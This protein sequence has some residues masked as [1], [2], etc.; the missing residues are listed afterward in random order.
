MSFIT[1]SQRFS[2]IF[3]T[4]AMCFIIALSSNV[5]AITWDNVAYYKLDETSGTNAVDETGS[6]NLTNYNSVLVNSSG[7]IGTSYNWS[8]AT[9]KY[10]QTTSDLIS[11]NLSFNT[12]VYV[13]SI[14]NADTILSIYDSSPDTS[15]TIQLINTTHIRT[16]CG[17]ATCSGFDITYPIAGYLNKWTMVSITVDDDSDNITLYLDGSLVN[18]DVGVFAGFTNVDEFDIGNGDNR[19]RT[20]A[21]NGRQDEISVWDR[22]LVSDDITDLYNGGAGLAYNNQPNVI[23]ITLDSPSNATTI[24][25]IGANFTTSS[26]NLSSISG[27]WDNI[28]YY[29][30][31]DN[32]TL[33]NQTFVNLGSVESFENILFIDDFSLNNYI[34]NV[35]SCWS[36]S[37]DSGCVLASENYTFNVVPFGV[38]D[39]DYLNVTLSGSTDIFTVN[40]SVLSGLRM[41]TIDFTYNGTLYNA[42]FE[43]YE[44]GKYYA[45]IDNSVP[46]VSS[47][48]NITFYWTVELESGFTQNT[49]L[50][51][52]TVYL[53]AM[54]NCST[55]TNNIFNFTLVDE[56]TQNTLVG[57]TDNTSIYV[58]LS[59]SRLDS[60]ALTI[61]FSYYYNKINPAGVCGNIDLDSSRYLL[62]GIIEYYAT[63]RFV[64]YYNIQDYLL[65]NTTDHQ[66][67]TL[68]NL[69]STRGQ[70]FKITYKDE[71]FNTVPGALIQI[72]RKYIAEGIFKTVEIPMIS[73]AGY[74]IAHLIRNDAIYTL[75]IINDGV[76][77]ATFDDIVADCQNPSF[78][79]CSININSF[80]SSVSPEDFTTDDGFTGAL[81]YN[82][83]TKVVS[84]I[85]AIPSGV[86]AYTSLNVTLFD[87]FGNTS[88]CSDGLNA[89]GG[90][91]SCTVPE[92]FG[93][94]S[95]IIKVFSGGDEK[96]SAV[97]FLSTDPSE[98][99]GTNLVFLSVIILLLLM[100]MGIS[101]NPVTLG[102]IMV[103]GAIILIALNIITNVGLIGNGATILW[104]IVA[105]II[106]LIK[107]SGRQ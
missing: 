96:R 12:W 10:L 45:T 37:S 44:T 29:V 83:T 46:Q 34:W 55:Y 59:L 102:I 51:N 105:V 89:A 82:K 33:H 60:T 95:I 8:G 94:Q 43:E 74:T 19:V 52:Q 7:K 54:D 41:A 103:I 13:T 81:R 5:S 63:G 68:Y 6:F 97:V 32:G 92:S 77:V 58:D 64:E 84:I 35:E 26:T 91:L 86:P 87:G 107:G 2:A 70:E 21:I 11:N 27:T 99:W 18:Y 14:D 61:N 15:L 101:D 4:I 104:F 3:F 85:Y 17:G 88:I 73:S 20:R 31:I 49:T 66:N 65:T 56:D 50:H 100:G 76:V 9:D 28:T 62:D 30:W 53:F 16:T 47:D 36:N 23:E 25:D 38:I 106:L 79:E 98:I 24:S 93:N 42:D 78:T 69:N 40:I 80:S 71:N 1:S 57:A 72:Q 39:E 48:T 75:V 22:V 90:T 67:I